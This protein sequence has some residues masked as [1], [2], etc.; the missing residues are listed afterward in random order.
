PGM[1]YLG[2]ELALGHRDALRLGVTR[3]HQALEHDGAVVDVLVVGEVH[4]TQSAVRDA[5]LDYILLCDL[6]VRR[7]LRQERVRAATVR[8]PPLRQGAAVGCR[9][10]D[11]AAAVPAEPFR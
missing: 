3:V 8:A 11:R 1:R 6:V 9:P 10:A 5:A 7:K 2:E 4:P